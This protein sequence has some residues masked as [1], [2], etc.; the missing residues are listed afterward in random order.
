MKVIADVLSLK[1]SVTVGSFVRYNEGI[2]A[3]DDDGHSRKLSKIIDGR[4]LG[5]IV[6]QGAGGFDMR[7]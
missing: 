2:E 1:T 7:A 3:V 6:P 5:I 4:S